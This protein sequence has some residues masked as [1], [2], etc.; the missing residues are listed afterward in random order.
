MGARGLGWM[1]LALVAAAPAQSAAELTASGLQHFYNLEYP[2]AIAIFTQETQLTPDAA[3]AWNHLAQALLYQEM[4]RTGEL[5]TT[6][7]G[8]GNA[9]LGRKR[10]QASPA[11][12][13]AF[14][15]ANRRAF[16]CARDRLATHAGDAHA[17]YDLAVAWA[18]LANEKFSLEHAWWP[19]LSD[20][21]HARAEA[22]RT[23]KLEPEFV[24]PELILGV[25]SYVAGS[26]PWSARLLS[27]VVGYRGNKE[28]G[29]R[30]IADVAAHGERARTDA[31][32]LLAVVDRRDGLNRQAAPILLGLSTQYPRNVLFA[33]E[34]GEAL[35][36]SG[37][38]QAAERQDQSVL[39]RATA[40]APG[41]NRA[42]LGRVWYDLGEIEA[43][44]GRWA[45]AATDYRHAAAV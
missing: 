18:M 37:N 40:G 44:D 9:F 22:S 13:T 32:V 38:H 27:S 2:Q 39:R 34:A 15:R 31:S 36:A 28:Q 14:D 21:K 43:I 6:L 41:F 25:Q 8:K 42:P 35:E 10:L 33:I 1:L 29:R 11:A 3:A 17:H 23:V 19:A 26:L 16:A 24:D 30:L 5:E 20:A 4:Y 45:E 12:L 7:Y